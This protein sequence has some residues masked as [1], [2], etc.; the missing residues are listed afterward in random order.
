GA[1][2]PMT[3]SNP[4][5]DPKTSTLATQSQYPITT[6]FASRIAF[7]HIGARVPAF[8]ANCMSSRADGR[9][10]TNHRG[11]SWSPLLNQPEPRARLGVAFGEGDAAPQICTCNTASEGSASLA[12]TL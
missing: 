8:V 3:A 9:A 2:K 7:A 12:Q 4:L 11:E 6:H 1:D 5:L 10:Q